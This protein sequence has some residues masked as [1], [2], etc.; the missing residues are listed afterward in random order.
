[1]VTPS[2]NPA[3]WPNV[4]F[5]FV[6][7]N[8]EDNVLRI[9][10]RKYKS[11]NYYAYG[12]TSIRDHIDWYHQMIDVL[13]EKLPDIVRVIHYEEMVADPAT[14][15][16][17]A[18]DLCGLEMAG[19]PLPSLGDDRGCAEPYRELMAAAAAASEG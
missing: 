10:M 14:A 19:R 2:G 16:G 1:M 7:R 18:A 9:Y 8:L 4:R 12:L 13:A 15:V 6:K 11:G 17:I 5:I 3:A